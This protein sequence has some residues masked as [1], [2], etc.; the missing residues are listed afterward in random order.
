[1]SDVVRLKDFARVPAKLWREG[2]PC[3][4]QRNL[5]QG[6]FITLLKS[7][8]LVAFFALEHRQE[9]IG[10]PLYNEA[11]VSSYGNYELTYCDDVTAKLEQRMCYG[12]DDTTARVEIER[13]LDLVN[14]QGVYL[15]LDL[16]GRIIRQNEK[17]IIVPAF[18]DGAHSDARIK[19][20]IN[21]NLFRSYLM[22]VGYGVEEGVITMR[23]DIT[24][25]RKTPAQEY[26]DRVAEAAAPL[27][28]VEW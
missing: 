6:D 14:V 24:P 8:N 17:V 7:P 25:R 2:R 18:E 19:L 10:D 21:Y 15:K 9:I 1:M 16:I 4:T 11:M 26:A 28:K 27:Q 3:I 20:P 23:P 13:R 12:V 22:Q 5:T